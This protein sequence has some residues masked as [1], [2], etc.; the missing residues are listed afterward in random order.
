V[1]S[2]LE[3]VLGSWQPGLSIGQQQPWDREVQFALNDRWK[4]SAISDDLDHDRGW[5]LL[6]WCENAAS[7]AVR[8]S[9]PELLELCVVGLSLV[10]LRHVDPREV[11]LVGSLVRRAAELLGLNWPEFRERFAANATLVR[12][13]DGFPTDVSA[14]GHQE[15]GNGPTFRFEKVR[16]A[17]MSEEELLRRLNRD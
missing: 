12:L 3:H 14:G 11:K 5:T 15:H 8:T 7:V 4:R 1:A 6:G 9:D 10:P 17:Q 13:A 2:P 16:L